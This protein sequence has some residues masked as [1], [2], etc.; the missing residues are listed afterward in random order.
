M[1]LA[2][3]RGKLT[4]DQ[5]NRED[6]L[7]SNVFSFF[8]Y[9]PRQIFLAAFM[10]SLGLK[11]S[12]EEAEKAEF[13]FWPRYEDNTEP[14]LV[15]ILGS[16][17]LL[18]EAKYFSGFGEETIELKHQLIREIDGGLSEAK[19]LNKEFHIVAITAHYYYDPSIFSDVP[20]QYTKKLIW[21]NWQEISFLLKQ[22]LE[23]NKQLS[24]EIFDFATDLYA[25][26]VKKRLRS[27]E[28]IST[29]QS[30]HGSLVSMD[31]VFFQAETAQYRGDFLGFVL[32][33]STVQKQNRQIP[34][35]IFYSPVR[36]FFRSLNSTGRMSL[37]DNHE[38]FLH[39]SK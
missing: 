1:Y 21:V 27:F 12:N 37:T 5:E 31:N 23:V 34:G 20:E 22:V 30:F 4:K 29:Y 14:D 15:I 7:T 6:I 11:V 36:L 24:P 32:T 25:L 13:H 9:A 16:Y 26:L 35:P 38:I 39:R 3:L 10:Q 18:F 2:E 33:L 28:G 8:K 17:Y 19:N